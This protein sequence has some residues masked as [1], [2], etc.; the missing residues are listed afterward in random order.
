MPLNFTHVLCVLN[1]VV[2]EATLVDIKSS[3]LKFIENSLK[4]GNIHMFL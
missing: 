3:G 2:R 1:F 4:Q